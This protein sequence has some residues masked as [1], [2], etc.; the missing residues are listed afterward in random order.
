MSI[1][2]TIRDRIFAAA[3]EL[4]KKEQ[5]VTVDAVRRIAKVSMND[6]SL[7][8]KEWRKLRTTPAAT[9]VG[10]PVP[11]PVT[12]VGRAAVENIWKTAVEIATES[13]A[14]A[15]AGLEQEKAETEKELQEANAACDNE[16]AANVALQTRLTEIE[17]KATEAAATAEAEITEARRT[18][19]AL[20]EEAHTATARA[21]EI[22]KRADDLKGALADAQALARTQAADLDNERRQLA[23]VREQLES[24][25]A[26]LAT[27]KAQLEVEQRVQLDQAARLKQ[28]EADLAKAVG[29]AASAR[30]EAARLQGRCE[31]LQANQ[32]E[33][34]NV[35]KRAGQQDTK[36]KPKKG[37]DEP[38]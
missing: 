8:M 33:L 17:A 2:T 19:A 18:I 20:T 34:M 4:A 38:A 24:R 21:G 1:T 5:P 28:A 13:F 9:P 3:N 36:S 12:Q 6:C 11:E 10:I 16:S 14:S 31:T 35:V 22:E 29:V 37:S 15:K 23:A 27:V 7:A 26:E 25:S 30:E 32:A